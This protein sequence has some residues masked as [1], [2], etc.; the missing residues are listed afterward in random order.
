[1][2]TALSIIKSIE[3]NYS[4]CDEI[5]ICGGGAFNIT[6][7]SNL[8][9][10]ADQIFSNKVVVGSTELLDF[11][12]KSVE[13]GLFAWLAMSRINKHSLDYTNIT[14]SKKPAIL[15]NIYNPR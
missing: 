13:A 5:F 8:S 1:M 14:G 15:G 9:D 2:F 3:K 4:K 11:N 6:L 12:P 7:M 10:V